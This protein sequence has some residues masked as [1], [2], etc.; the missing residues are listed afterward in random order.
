MKKLYILCLILIGSLVQSHAQITVDPLP[1][2]GSA[3]CTDST[4]PDANADFQT[5]LMNNGNGMASSGCGTITDP[6]PTSYSPGDW[7]TSDPCNVFVDVTWD[8]EDDCGSPVQSVTATFTIVDADPPV[9]NDPA[10]DDDAE[11]DGTDTDSH[12]DFQN[13]LN[14]NANAD[15]D[16]DCSADNNLTWF[17]DYDISNF[18]PDPACD[19]NQFAGSI[20]VNFWT[21]DECG[22]VSNMTLATFTIEDTT[23]PQFNDSPPD[24]TVECDGVGNTIDIQAWVDDYVAN[25]NVS[26]GCTATADLVITHDWDGS[27]F[28]ASCDET[29]DVTFTVTDQ[30]GNFGEVE[31]TIEVEDTTPP[32]LDTPAQ[33]LFLTCDPANNPMDITDWLASGAN[34][35]YSDLCTP[36]GNL[37]LTDDYSGTPP[38][39]SAAETITFFV[40]DECGV[41]LEYTADLIIDDFDAPSITSIETNPSFEECN[42]EEISEGLI[43]DL[44]DDIVA[45]ATA[46]DFND[47]TLAGD[48]IW[49]VLPDPAPVSPTSPLPGCE[50]GNVAGLYEF[51][52]TVYD[53]CGNPS[54]TEIVTITIEDTTPPI[55]PGTAPGDEDYDC[56]DEIPP[57][58]DL[59]AIDDCETVP[60]TF[61]ENVLVENCPNQITLERIWDFEDPCGNSAG[62]HIQIITVDDQDGP[63][64]LGDEEEYLPGDISFLLAD[65][66]SGFSFPNGYFENP[67]TGEEWPDFPLVEGVHFE[68]NCGGATFMAQ[69]PPNEEFGEGVTVVTY[70]VTDAC[71]NTL[72]HEFEVELICSNCEGGGLFCGECEDSIAD[73]C[74]TCNVDAL[75]NG[76]SSCTPEYD[77]GGGTQPSQPSPLCNGVGVPHNMSW[78]AFVAGGPDLCVTVAPF[79]CAMGTGAIGL[80]SGVYDF[81]EDEG[82]MCLGGEAFCSQGLDPID[83]EV[84]DLIVGNTYFLFVD[85]CNGAEC[86]YEITIEKGFEFIIDTPEEVVVEPDCEQLPALPPNTFCPETVL[87]FDIW[88]MGDSP[89]DMGEYDAPGPYDPM[90]NATFYWTFEPDIEGM[91]DG[92]WNQIDDGFNI[93]PLSFSDVVVPTTYTICLTDIIAECTDQT[94]DECCLD[95][96]IQPLPDEMYGPYRVCVEDLI[97]VNGWD[98]SQVGDDPNMDGIEWLGPNNI[99][100]DQ[101]QMAPMGILTFEVFD[102]SCGCSFNQSVEIIPIGSLDPEPVTLYMF[103]CQFR[104]EDGD[105]EAYEWI[106][107]SIEFELNGDE[108]EQLFNLPMTSNQVDWDTERCDSLLLVT[109]DTATVT[110]TISSGPCTPVGTEYTFMLELEALYDL[111]PDHPEI[112]PNYVVQW[113]SLASGTTVHQG[114][115][116]NV[117][118]GQQ[119]LYIVRVEYF[120]YDGAYGEESTISAS[121]IKEFGPYDLQTGTAIPPDFLRLDTLFCENDLTDHLFVVNPF[122]GSDYEWTFP[123]GAVG[124]LNP[125]VNDTAIVDFTGY[126][127]NT[128]LPITVIANTFC[129][130]SDPVEIF[131]STTPLPVP[132]IS[133]PDQVCVNDLAEAT[134]VG[135]QT[136]IM[137]YSWSSLNYANGNQSGPGPVNYSSSTPG[138][139]DIELT[140]VDLNGCESEPVFHTVDVIPELDV[141]EI[142]CS[143]TASSITFTWDPIVGATGY[144]INVLDSPAGT[145]TVTQGPGET[146]IVFDPLNTL[147]EVEIEVIAN[148]PPPCGDSAA[149]SLRCQAQDCPDPMWDLSGFVDTSFCINDPIAPFSFVVEAFDDGVATYSGNGVTADGMF[150]PTS[151]DLVVGANVITMTYTYQLGNCVRVRSR[152]VTVYPTPSVDFTV[153]DNEICLGEFVTIDDSNVDQVA[154]WNGYDGGTVN[155]MNQISWNTPGLKT[156]VLDVTAPAN[157]GSCMNQATAQVMVLDTVTLGPITCIDTDLD[158]VHFDWDDA[159]NATGYEITYLVNGAN[160]VTQTITD[161]EIIIDMLSP[162]DEVD[163]TVTAL[164][165]NSCP[166][167]VQAQ[168]CIAVNCVPLIFSAPICSDSGIDFVEFDWDPVNGASTFDVYIDGVLVGNQDSTS[169][170]VDG[171][172]PGDA[173]ELRVVAV[174]DLPCPDQERTIIC[175]AGDCPDVT[176]TFDANPDYCWEAGAQ[177]I[178]LGATATGGAGGG[179]GEWDS[180]FVDANGVF[181]PDD[182]NNTS[183][184]IQ[185]IYTE[186]ACVYMDDV[187]ILINIIPVA[188]INVT[189]DDICVSE[190][191]MVSS[192]FNA[193]NGETPIWDFGPANVLSGSGYGPYELMY[194]DAGNYTVTLSIDNNGCV[195][196]EASTTIEVDP[197][198]ISPEIRCGDTDENTEVVFEWDPVVGVTEYLVSIDGVQVGNQT[199]TEYTVTGLA[200]GQTVEITLEFFTNSSCSL[201]PITFEC[202]SNACPN[203][204]FSIDPYDTMICLDGSESS[205]QLNIQIIDPPSG[206]GTGVWTGDGINAN[207]VFNP[208]GLSPQVDLPLTYTIT[209]EQCEYDT[210]VFLTLLQAPQITSVNPIDPDCYLP[211]QNFGEID[212]TVTGGLPDYS[213]QVDGGAPQSSSIF[214]PVNPGIHNM[215]VTDDNGCTTAVQFDIIPAV[216]PPLSIDGPLFIL[217]E[218]TG[219]YSLSTTAE[220]IGDVIWLANG[221]IICQGVDC[222]PVQIFGGN[223]LDDFDLTVQV[224]FNE[225]CFI[226][227][228][229]RVDVII[230]RKWYIPNVIATSDPSNSDWKMFVDGNIAVLNVKIYDRW[231]ELVHDFDPSNDNHPE[232]DLGWDGTWTEPGGGPD[233]IQG[234]Y[235]YLISMEVDGRPMTEAG[236]VTVLR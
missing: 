70:T 66:S 81:C 11:C 149:S 15:F 171:L 216:E 69:I 76:F 93:P 142:N 146:S 34:A 162:G 192:P 24:L 43:Q 79:Q 141:P 189:D 4:D 156:I 126:D 154:N 14:N 118:D 7:D 100:L 116:Y 60:A 30:C 148:G 107:P 28:T 195:S 83:Y 235:V 144:T 181:T 9:L 152:T 231:G 121:C 72:T 109:V 91:S 204:S 123:A 36:A 165:V 201:E 51:D 159:T 236:D 158:F 183:Y 101:V 13:W 17:N 180:P 119:G 209:Y 176:I 37:I 104:D 61:T 223:Y 44:I 22:N 172:M 78:F 164:S 214:S 143:T 92:A 86:D 58:P 57:P 161:S 1:S 105:P 205:Q 52:V 108:N 160:P 114:P 227:T 89:S 97:D 20:D 155:A 75:L 188:D 175:T 184:N 218:E 110:G 208:S 18:I 200:E 65:C 8:V 35:S 212:V 177:P 170:F 132:Q 55:I 102:P 99:S 95:I 135:D 21:E 94:C 147:E 46:S 174:N 140:V 48:L 62:Q 32:N 196:E 202:T 90:L 96:T 229:I 77:Q 210:T 139:F 41:V 124:T 169:F 111:H 59:F 106:W 198:L 127:F 23:D 68:D 134:F 219:T 215:L 26:D 157:Q 33:D 225:D 211:E 16:D 45:A 194:D 87:Q 63:E 115:S 84:N 85:G 2:N 182:N 138:T 206:Q 166:N 40:E 234:V 128:N 117:I 133:A 130:A 71:G 173:V 178:Q 190:V 186:G 5:W 53:E 56:G 27:G 64:W 103:D 3:D 197:E 25:A 224:F 67:D 222:D 167:V 221:E 6:W 217:D 98:P 113:V 187:D 49:E 137:T 203:S 153:S 168:S 12:P 42:S 122:P 179:T 136:Q 31:G 10:E 232:V 191:T 125:P 129:G 163:I 88:H 112:F 82:G 207:G 193:T 151:P 228:S 230:P 150:D 54:I 199:T 185:Y 233:V 131:V 50:N 47:C 74:F 73:G 29:I 80:Q 213:Y 120:F 145:S 39:C 19:P 220:N 38:E 226:E